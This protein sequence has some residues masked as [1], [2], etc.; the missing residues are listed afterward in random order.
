MN[1]RFRH[2][3]LA[4]VAMLALINLLAQPARADYAVGDKAKLHFNVFPSG[5]AVD[6]ADLKGQI[7]V[8]DFFASWCEPCMAQVE[9]L[10]KLSQNYA[11]RGVQL[12]GVSLDNDS[13]TLRTAMEDK[14]ISWPVAYDGSGWSGAIPMA[15]GV[16]SIPQTFIV[17]PDGNVVWRGL[18]SDLD[19]A[20]DSAMKQH[21]PTATNATPIAG[22][23]TARVAQPVTPQ[24][25]PQAIVPSTVPVANDQKIA[26]DLL[27]EAHRLQNSK[28]DI[29][30]YDKFAN[31]VSTYGDTPSA[32]DARAAIAR[33]DADKAFKT[34]YDAAKL[35]GKAN[36]SKDNGMLDTATQYY[37]Q[38]L[39]DYP[40]SVEAKEARRHL[41]E[42]SQQ[43]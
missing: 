18:P 23:A 39:H 27:V 13:G 4:T 21:A 10:S 29:K 5:A 25:P 11:G 37:Q 43:R 15:W 26:S 36:M 38:I 40:G 32:T 22:M 8:V 9:H 19:A 2:S 41:D 33:Y 17:G 42:M 3:S 14:G 16:N 35:L 6:L 20:L 28:Q 1:S 31:I 7:V 30:A 34:R 12:I 24:P